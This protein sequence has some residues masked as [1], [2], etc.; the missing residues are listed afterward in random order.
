MLGRMNEFATRLVLR[1]LAAGSLLAWACGAHAQASASSLDGRSLYG[2]CVVCHQPN[3]DGSPDGAIP[4]LAGQR[5]GYLLEQLRGFGTRER[6]A[7]GMDVVAAH[8]TFRDPERMLALADYL[9]ALPPNRHPVRGPA[10][11]DAAGA[12]L[13][14]AR[15]AGCHGVRGRGV[16]AQL[17]VLACQHYPY[18]RRRLDVLP[19]AHGKPPAPA[20]EAAAA[21]LP[22]RSKDALAAYISHLCPEHP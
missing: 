14:R 22:P 11:V 8:S 6:R 15:C 3:A 7:P 1:A 20:I 13:Y 12:H 2:A 5:R 10:E 4:S 21:I 17:P 16:G 19:A 18:L 9:A